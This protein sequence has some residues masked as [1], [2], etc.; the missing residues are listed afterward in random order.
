[1][2]ES[3]DKGRNY[4]RHIQKITSKMLNLEVKRDSRSGAGLHKADVRDRYN[5]LPIFI[6]CKHHKTIK[7]KEWWKD[8]DGKSSH[9]QAP[10]VVFP[11]ET[12]AGIEDLACIRYSDLLQLI[13]EAMDWK[14]TADFLRKPDTIDSSNIESDDTSKTVSGE[15]IKEAMDF[16]QKAA[17]QKQNLKNCRNGHI[18]DDYGYCQIKDCKYRRGYKPPK[19]KKKG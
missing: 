1:M 15:P 14:E 9:G 4:E 13:A 12:K 16:S 5:Q 8:A 10:V 19:N 11:Y 17:S 7:L 18:S 3:F 2:S 6:E